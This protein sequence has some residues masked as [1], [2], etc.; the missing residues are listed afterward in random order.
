MCSVPVRA[1]LQLTSFQR[2]G[3]IIL[4][5]VLDP[6]LFGSVELSLVREHRGHIGC[7]PELTAN[8]TGL[9]AP[10]GEFG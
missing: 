7:E 2:V 6:Q 1:V 5:G 8:F 3:R 9:G 10:V 4:D